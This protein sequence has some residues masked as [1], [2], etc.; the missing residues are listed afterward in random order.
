MNTS[1]PGRTS[2]VAATDEADIF[3]ALGA[4]YIPPEP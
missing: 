4:D 2:R 1:W 3:A